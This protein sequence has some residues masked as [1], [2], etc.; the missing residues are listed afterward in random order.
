MSRLEKTSEKQE[1]NVRKEGNMDVM[2]RDDIKT[3]L[4]TKQQIEKNKNLVQPT[5]I[6][7]KLIQIYMKQY[8]REEKIYDMENM[9]T[10]DLKHLAL[11]YSSK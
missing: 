7:E 5:A 3:L 9:M 8:L 10:W 1:E 6:D 11:S 4:K 2:K